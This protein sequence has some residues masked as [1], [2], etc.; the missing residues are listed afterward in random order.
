MDFNLVYHVEFVGGP[1]DGHIQPVSRPVEE[2][3]DLAAI[4]VNH[5]V[6]EKLSS[7]RS[8]PRRPATSIAVYIRQDGTADSC[9]RYLGPGAPSQFRLT[10]W[11]G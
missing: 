11:R 9:Y 1:L 8:K 3:N 7:R 5:N 6:V 2:L 10:A 4:P